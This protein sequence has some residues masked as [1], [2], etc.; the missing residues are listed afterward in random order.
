VQ[1][2]GWVYLGLTTNC[3]QCH[4]HKFDPITAKDYYGLAAFFRNTTQGPKD[5]N[6]KDGL[7][8]TIVV[9]GDADAPRWKALPGEI[10]AATNTRDERRKAARPEFDQWVAGVSPD[11]LDDNLSTDGLIVHAPLNEGTGNETTN[12]CEG[13]PTSKKFKATGDVTWVPDGKIGSAPVMKA[14][15]TFDLGAL[16]DWEKDQKFSYGA[17]VKAGRKGVS[18]G[19]IARMDQDAGHRG[20]DL[21]Q[22]DNA[23]AVHMVDTWPENAMKVATRA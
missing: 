19:I 11:S 3:S 14:G 23:F 16:G 22:N 7:G 2:F 9:P 10:A 17:W 15:G 13:S 5:G 12:A 4:D 21:C 6:V 8:P 18:G 20:W 1:T